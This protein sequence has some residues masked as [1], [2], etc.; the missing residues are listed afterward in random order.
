MSQVTHEHYTRAAES[1]RVRDRLL[2]L[3]PKLTANLYGLGHT[4]Q[5]SIDF[6]GIAIDG[7]KGKYTSPDLEEVS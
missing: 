6:S 7:V 4:N 1:A 5:L 2:E 3:A